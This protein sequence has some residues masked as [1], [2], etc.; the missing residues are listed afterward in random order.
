MGLERES[1]GKEGELEPERRT[2]RS[3][4]A[5]PRAAREAMAGAPR[6]FMLLMA[7]KASSTV[8][9]VSQAMV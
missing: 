1:R 7:A 4:A 2:A 5:I 8:E 3:S 9:T 6:I